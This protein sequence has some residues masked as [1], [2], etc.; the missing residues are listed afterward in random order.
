MLLCYE[1]NRSFFERGG[2]KTGR[3]DAGVY[4]RESVGT[5]IKP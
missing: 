1:R 2:K 5:S 4:Y 3:E